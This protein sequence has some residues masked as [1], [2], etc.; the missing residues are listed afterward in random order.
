MQSDSPRDPGTTPDTKS[1]TDLYRDVTRTG[2]A[3]Y[4]GDNT[5]DL[6]NVHEAL[7]EFW[8]RMH[9]LADRHTADTIRDHAQVEHPEQAWD[10]QAATFTTGRFE[11][12][13]R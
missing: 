12:R 9:S 8:Q 13:T 3:W 6:D 11:G 10:A 7:G 4:A 1:L 2:D 5:V